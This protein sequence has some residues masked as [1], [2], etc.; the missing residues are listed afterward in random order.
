MKRGLALVAVVAGVAAAVTGIARAVEGGT[1]DS[2]NQYA[3]VGLVVL[4]TSDGR[5]LTRCT[6]AL[7]S[8]TVLVTAAH[9]TGGEG[10]GPVPT[11]A[12]VWFS[13]GYPNQIPRGTWNATN[14][15]PCQ[16]VAGLGYPCTGDVGG[17][18]ATAPGW[19]GFIDLPDSHDLGVVLL[20]HPVSLPTYPLVGPGALDALTTR[21]GTQATTFTLVGYGVQVETPGEEVALRT[22]VVGEVQLTNLQSSLVD[23]HNIRVSASPGNGTGGGAI[24]SGDSGGPLFLDGRIAAVASFSVGKYCNG[25]SGAFRLDTTEAQGFLGA[26]LP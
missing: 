3:G 26:Y 4:Y 13:N 10:T 21:R 15:S 16:G 12:Q 23:G 7:I 25:N 5:P 24:C 14:G 18:P 1:P 19:T 17:S 8:P 11:R 6:G 20:D 9:C 2:T 22:R